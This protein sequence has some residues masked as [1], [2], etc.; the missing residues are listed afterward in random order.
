MLGLIWAGVVTLARGVTGG[1]VAL[2]MAAIAAVLMLVTS[3]N[4]S[5]MVLVAGAVGAVALH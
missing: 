3:W 4:Q 1:P 2:A 5:L